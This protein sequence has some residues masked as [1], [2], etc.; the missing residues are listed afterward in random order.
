MA[1]NRPYRRS[2]A[3]P[4]S[5]DGQCVATWAP[6]T[7]PPWASRGAQGGHHDTTCAYDNNRPPLIGGG[8][9]SFV[10][11]AEAHQHV[12]GGPRECLRRPSRTDTA[13]PKPGDAASATDTHHTR[14]RV[15]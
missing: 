8:H 4:G 15:H 14:T 12:T 10:D 7:C 1:A 5:T 13:L 6:D 3:R 9:L 2:R 11:I